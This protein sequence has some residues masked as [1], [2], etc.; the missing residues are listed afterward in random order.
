MDRITTYILLL[1]IYL[2]RALAREKSDA[3][4]VADYIGRISDMVPEEVT[5]SQLWLPPQLYQARYHHVDGSEVKA[6]QIV[7]TLV[8]VALELLSDDDQTNDF[9]AYGKLLFIFI[10]LGDAKNAA[11]A[12]SMVAL[13]KRTDR[14]KGLEYDMHMRCPGDC[15]HVWKYPDK[16]WVSKDCIAVFMEVNCL[17]K[18][19]ENKLEHKVC[20][21]NHH[22]LE[23]P[24][25]DGDRM[26][27]LPKGIIPWGDQNLP[28]DGWKQEIRKA[29]IEVD[30]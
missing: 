7:R 24:K 26:E 19:R 27:S 5:S 16:T 10:P 17:K 2:W 15:D 9:E 18:L 28:L 21:P 20:N 30:A 13:E 25:W 4:S 14:G 23:V 6:R 1:F 29:Y 22:F 12:L 3:D 11:T 8:Q